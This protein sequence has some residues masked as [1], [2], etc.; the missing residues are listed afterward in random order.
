MKIA[1]CYKFFQIFP[2]FLKNFFNIAKKAVLRVFFFAIRPFFNV[3]TYIDDENRDLLQVF[4][5]FLKK[6]FKTEKIPAR[7][8]K[9]TAARSK[10]RTNCEN[11]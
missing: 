11:L 10:T 1:I 8:S 6:F 3:F 5:I 9:M 2:N 7:R 4:S